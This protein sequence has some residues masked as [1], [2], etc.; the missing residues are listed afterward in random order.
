MLSKV[1]LQAVKRFYY[2]AYNSKVYHK[3][4]KYIYYSI[5]LVKLY[6]LL[7]TLC[8]LCCV[9]LVVLA[10]CNIRCVTNVV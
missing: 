6:C 9:T 8:N 3:Q 10:M 1:I 5:V 2:Y 4:D 7:Y